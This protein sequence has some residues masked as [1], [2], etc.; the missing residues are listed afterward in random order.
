M[1]KSKKVIISYGLWLVPFC[2]I[3]AW[4]ILRL[5]GTFYQLTNN[6]SLPLARQVKVT[7]FCLF[8]VV[9]LGALNV[10]RAKVLHLDPWAPKRLKTGEFEVSKEKQ[11][12][13]KQ[14]IDPYY[15]SGVP[16]GYV[17]GRNG[18][19]YVRIPNDQNNIMHALVLGSPGSGKSTTLLTSLIAN[20]NDS[21]KADKKTVFC[22]DVKP[23]LLR[24]SVQYTA[25]EDDGVKAI[26]PSSLDP[27]YFGWDLY[28]GLTNDS[29]IDDVEERLNGIAESLI[30][31]RDDSDNAIFFNT[32]RNLMVA[33]LL[34]GWLQGKDFIDSIKQLTTVP[35][36]DL[37][38][39]I[40]VD[41]NLKNDRPY[42][43]DKVLSIVSTYADDDSD[44]IKNSAS[45]MVEQL[46]IF[47]RKSVI[48]ALKDNPRKASPIDLINDISIFLTIPDGLLSTYR[49]LFNLMVTQT[50][51]YLLS[52]PD[53]VRSEQEC[54]TIW[55]IIDEFGSLGKI[56]KINE[57]LAQLRSRKVCIWLIAQSVAQI[58]ATYSKAIKNALINNCSA[59]ILLGI[60]DPESAK[61]FSLMSGEYREQMYSVHSGSKLF[62]V[63]INPGESQQFRP[64]LSP[65]DFYKLRK[66]KKVV[67]FIDGATFFLNKSP[68]YADKKL[69][70]IERK[71][72][73]YN[74]QR[75]YSK[76]S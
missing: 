39:Q 64:I 7:L 58:E 17:I 20:F 54:R 51:D 65:A 66:D 34:Y 42:E 9:F 25:L 16:D 13:L 68:F 73:K 18:N 41:E 75:I 63:P 38:A 30:S 62:G 74:M 48:Y 70:E 1:E 3:L 6:A 31:G 40:K 24:K 46:K 49:P 47:N 55:L 60:N 59:T 37:L 35:L 44:M 56:P 53:E 15:L 29:D 36:Q 67:A 2:L 26:N 50:L 71:N 10:V 22:V 19:N 43:Y 28:Y 72:N 21:K 76:D 52:L 4:A 61:E 8:P 33:I 11:K 32:A 12:A 69:A 27:A 5:E 23:E 14:R 45:T 57:A